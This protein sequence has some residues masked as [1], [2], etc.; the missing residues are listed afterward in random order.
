ME[1][2]SPD[3]PVGSLG[4]G[5]RYDN[6]AGIFAGK[7]I[8]AVGF[9]VGFD[10]TIEAMEEL[11]LF[12]ELNQTKILVTNSGANAAEI[13]NQLRNQGINAELF[14]DDKELDKQLKF[15]DKKRIPFVLILEGQK[16]ILKD[17]NTGNKKE[18]TLQE[19]PNAIT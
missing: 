19:L 18:V 2:E 7:E 13:A 16:I 14:V 10:R 4:G 8:P 17:M 6:L 15:A 1:I 5:G 11:N 9:A 12:P 3:Y